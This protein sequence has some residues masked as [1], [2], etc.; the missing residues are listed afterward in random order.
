MRTLRIA[1]LLLLCCAFLSA[2]GDDDAVGLGGDEVGGPCHDEND[3]QFR[4]QEGGEFP[5]GTCTLPC[6]ID[7][8]CPLGTYCVHKEE[9]ICLL[10]CEHPADCRDGYTCKGVENNGT[11]GESLVCIHD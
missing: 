7:D 1:S 11:E 8:D 3:C 9:G 10:G 5:E 4:C 2:C 6:N